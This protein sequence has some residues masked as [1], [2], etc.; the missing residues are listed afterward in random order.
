MIPDTLP[1]NADIMPIE[2]AVIVA[3]RVTVEACARN[4]LWITFHER[5]RGG[6]FFENH[7][8]LDQAV[9]HFK[10]IVSLE[11]QK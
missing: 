6:T 7:P 4:H 1:M 11:V 2:I 9:E 3:L 10:S 5:K 8:T